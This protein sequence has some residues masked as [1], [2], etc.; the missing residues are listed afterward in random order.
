MDLYQVKVAEADEAAAVS[1][2]DEDG[3]ELV[4]TDALVCFNPIA[5]DNYEEP[6]KPKRKRGGQ[7]NK[8]RARAKT[9][10]FD[11]ELYKAKKLEEEFSKR[12][13]FIENDFLTFFQSLPVW[14]LPNSSLLFSTQNQ[15]QKQKQ[16]QKQ[17]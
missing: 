4:T 10:Y 7:K 1:G 17:K 8:P 12:C 5:D 16:K 6:E 13:C 11:P 3:A 15:N 9:L 2:S 14:L